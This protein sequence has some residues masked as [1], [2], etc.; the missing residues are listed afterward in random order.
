MASVALSDGVRQYTDSPYRFLI[1]DE[2]AQAASGASFPVYDPATGHEIAQAA[3][4]GAEDVDRAVAAARRALHGPWR[5]VTPQERGRMIWR[6]ADLVEARLEDFSQLDS[7]DNG[8]PINEM[9]FFDVPFS[10][11]MLRYYAGWPTKITGETIPVSYPAS[12]GQ[13]FHSYTRR[14]PVGVVGA[15]IPWNLPLLMAIKKLAPA[16]ATGCT[17]VIKPAEQTPL[18]MPLLARLVLEAGIPEGVFNFVT[19]FGEVAGAALVAHPGVDKITFTGSSET[20]KAIVKSATDTLKRVS[21]ELGGK[22]PNIV[23]DDADPAA[24]IQGACDAIFACQGE[25]CIAGSRLYV[26]RGI[27]EEIVEGVV[28]RARRLRL[29]PGLDTDTEMG[30]LVSAEHLEKVSGYVELGRQEGAQVATGGGRWGQA[31][32]F[33]EPTVLVE[34]SSQMRVAREEI[35]GPVLTAIPFE[36]EQEVLAAAN[37]TRFGLAAAV[38]TKE[39]ARAH[40]VAAALESGQVWVNCYQACDAALPFGGYKESGWGRETCRENLDEY[41]ETKTVVVA[42]GATGGAGY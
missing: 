22:S 14:E 3:E 8:K 26:Q 16:L 2:W 23:F 1:G 19:G 35:F 27:F 29:G 31:G 9:R 25:S 12:F 32:Y 34:A 33:I 7:L 42:L 17:I 13:D 21:L 5:R 39:I 6:L 37:D 10:V 38:W 11:D 20:G 18:S 4:G 30:P 15:I 36:S 24:A 28:S 40:R 41:L